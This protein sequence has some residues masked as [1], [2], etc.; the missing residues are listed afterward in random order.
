MHQVKVDGFWIG[1]HEVTNAEFEAFTKDSGYKTIAE[2]KPKPEDFPEIPRQNFRES[3]GF[4]R[5][6]APKRGYP[7]GDVEKP[8]RIFG[9][10]EICA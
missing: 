5:F 9:V 3:R 1:K 4:H 7:V 6:Y 2:R 10:V 8:Q